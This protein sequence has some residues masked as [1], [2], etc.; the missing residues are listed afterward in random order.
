MIRK[1]IIKLFLTGCLMLSVTILQAQD[2]KQYLTPTKWEADNI[3]ELLSEF[4]NSKND[5]IINAYYDKIVALKKS[6]LNGI[7]AT[8]T[9]HSN[10]KK[11]GVDDDFFSYKQRVTVGLQW[12]ILKDGQK[13]SNLKA[14]EEDLNRQI[15]LRNNERHNLLIRMEEKRMIIEQAYMDE[16]AYWKNLEYHIN[17]VISEWYHRAYLQDIVT[18]LEYEI[19]QQR[20]QLAL[21]IEGVVDTFSLDSVVPILPQYYIKKEFITQL[22]SLAFRESEILRVSQELADK[23]ASKLNEITFSPNVRLNAFDENGRGFSSTYVSYGASLKVPFAIIKEKANNLE[24]DMLQMEYETAKASK[25]QEII[26]QYHQ[27]FRYLEEINFNQHEINKLEIENAGK[28]GDYFN[29]RRDYYN[30]VLKIIHYKKKIALQKR[31]AF[32]TLTNIIEK[33]ESPLVFDY[34][35]FF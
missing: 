31:N 11:I 19:A 5:S 17:T 7:N 33:S 29:V 12:D 35:V 10:S 3:I 30:R 20:Y 22:D 4:D 24:K 28:L 21:P 9:I 16:L 34:I 14:Q 27:V 18:R 32:Y 6:W 15:T 1:R 13:I 26:T 2:F 25:D 23:K 8:S